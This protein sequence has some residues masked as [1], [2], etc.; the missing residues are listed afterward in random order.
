MKT[1]KRILIWLIVFIVSI[2]FTIKENNRNK[3]LQQT[4]AYISSEFK[5]NNE[6]I[7]KNF[8]AQMTGYSLK[9]SNKKG[10]EDSFIITTDSDEISSNNYE[11]MGKAPLIVIMKKDEKRVNNYIENGLLTSSEKI[12]MNRKDKIEINFKKLMNAVK[13]NEK[14]NQ[15]IGKESKIF[16]PELTTTEGKL[17]K[18]FLLITANDGS[19]PTTQEEKETSQKQVEEFLE[20]PHVQEVNVVTRLTGVNDIAGDI[21]ITFENNAMQLIR[22]DIYVAYPKETVIK[23]VFFESN[24]EV[25]DKM[26]KKL[27]QRDFWGTYYSIEDLIC[28]NS[29]YRYE[30]REDIQVY[31]ENNDGNFD[32]VNFKDFYNYVEIP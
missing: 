24:S 6:E 29:R 14:W 9:V 2:V 32:R 5:E 20:S 1:G 13:E 22:E 31:R 7:E 10:R 4:T 17:F 23:E 15:L 21:Y 8:N 3:P 27:G 28:Q 25:G 30:G 18:E 19:Y 26:Q 11:V 16:Y 12:K